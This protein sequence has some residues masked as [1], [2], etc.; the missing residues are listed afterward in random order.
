MFNIKTYRYHCTSKLGTYQ[1]Y[2][3]FKNDSIP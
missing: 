3:V 1:V 2:Y